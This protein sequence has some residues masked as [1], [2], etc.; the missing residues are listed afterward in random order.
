MSLNNEPCMIWLFLIDL[1]PVDFKYYHFM[2]SLDK[3][4]GSCNS[5]NDLSL[6]IYVLSKTKDV[7]VKIFNIMT[8]RNEA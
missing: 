6:K 2:I 5:V 7:N 4:S 1:N 3:C 8:N